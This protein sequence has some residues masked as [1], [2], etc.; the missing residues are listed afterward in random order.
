MQFVV[1]AEAKLKR[2]P[3]TLVTAAGQ[4]YEFT[5][6]VAESEQDKA[7][8]LMFRTSIGEREGMLFPYGEPREIT[9]WMKNTYIPLDMV[10][11]KA[12]GT[13]H[14]IEARTEPFSEKVI[15]SRGNVTAVLE[16]AGGLAEKLGL[17]SGDK[18]V[19]RAFKP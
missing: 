1:P 18:V 17:K 6:E 2:E 9:M 8:G 10:F 5:I 12:D 15:A 14:R 7:T 11:I 16:I 4:R 3:A 19:H 13:I